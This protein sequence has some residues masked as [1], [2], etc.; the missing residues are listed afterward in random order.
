MA[1]ARWPG[2]LLG[3]TRQ[4]TKERRKEEKKHTR[5]RGDTTVDGRRGCESPYELQGTSQ[6]CSARPCVR[7]VRGTAWKEGAVS[8]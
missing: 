7:L 8:E 1:G 4:W 5:A 6:A 3:D 2:A